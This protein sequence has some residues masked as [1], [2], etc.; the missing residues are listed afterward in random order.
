MLDMDSELFDT[1]STELAVIILAVVMLYSKISALLSSSLLS[2]VS[3]IC[4]SGILVLNATCLFRNPILSLV[5][6]PIANLSN[7]ASF[8]MTRMLTTRLWIMSPLAMQLYPKTKAFL[9]FLGYD[10]I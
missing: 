6:T 3:S 9:N 2:N 5:L 4:Y 10:R 7:R 1:F 8:L